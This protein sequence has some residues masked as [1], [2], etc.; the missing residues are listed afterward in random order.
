MAPLLLISGAAVLL[1]LLLGIPQ[2]YR[3]ILNDARI[4]SK[5]PALQSRLE[6]LY[7]YPGSHSR[8]LGD[9][10]DCV[11]ASSALDAAHTSAHDSWNAEVRMK[12]GANGVKILAVCSAMSR[13]S[14]LLPS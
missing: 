5:D 11:R 4:I 8:I 3:A 2:C 14:R 1:S 6:I 9:M 7:A 10:L 13:W 12:S